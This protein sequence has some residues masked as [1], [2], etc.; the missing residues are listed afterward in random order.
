METLKNFS[1]FVLINPCFC[2]VGF[3]ITISLQSCVYLWSF[4]WFFI[5]VA[6]TINLCLIHLLLS[7]SHQGISLLAGSAFLRYTS[8]GTGRSPL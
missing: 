4:Y 8:R 7:Y 1:F 2:R 3:L 6:D 5:R